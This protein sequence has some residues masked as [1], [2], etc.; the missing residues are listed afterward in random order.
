MKKLL[1]FLVALGSCAGPSLRL[2]AAQSVTMQVQPDTALKIFSTYRTPSGSASSS[3]N[4]T[5]VS[6]SGICRVT[7]V[8]GTSRG[9]YIY[10]AGTEAGPCWIVASATVSG[11]TYRDSLYLHVTQQTR[12]VVA[13]AP[14]PAVPPPPPPPPPPPDSVTVRFMTPA[15]TWNTI[16]QPFYL[17]VAASAAVIRVRITHPQLD[18]TLAARDSDGHFGFVWSMAGVGSGQQ[19]LTAMGFAADGRTAT[20]S[21]SWN[22]S[23]PVPV[24]LKAIIK[25]PVVCVGLACVLDGSGSTGDIARYEWYSVCPTCGTAVNFTGPIWN[26]TAPAATTRSRALRVT[27]TTGQVSEDTTTFT[28]GVVIVPPPADTTIARFLIQSTP[29]PTATDS[30]R[31]LICPFVVFGDGATA[32]RAADRPECDALYA[33]LGPKLP[34]VAQQAVADAVCLSWSATPTPPTPPTATLP[35]MPIRGCDTVV[36]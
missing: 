1:A 15:A 2:I 16:N 20:A 4:V 12:F 36:P 35:L 31:L 3:T 5:V 14:P 26:Y 6:R 9:R 27:S 8:P 7:P 29:A 34:T 17:R 21:V 25:E 24:P 32:I 13:V 10:V 11:R 33:A 19:T 28:P 22:N 30:S 23:P 18:T